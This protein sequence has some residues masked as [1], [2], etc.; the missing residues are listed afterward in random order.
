[1]SLPDE[2]YSTYDIVKTKLRLPDDSLI[3]ELQVYMTE[4]DTMINNKLQSKLGSYDSRGVALVYPL[5]LT[6]VPALDE[7]LQ[8]IANDLVEGKFRLK[9][10]QKDILWNEAL[11]RLDVYL[12]R[13]FG[14]TENKGFRVI[15][16]ISFTPNFGAS[17]TLVTISGNLFI[18]NSTITITF[19]GLVVATT[20]SVVVTDANGNFSGVTFN[21]PVFAS[22]GQPINVTDKT[23]GVTQNFRV[24]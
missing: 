12:D 16:T 2:H 13:K 19:G 17:G 15:Q 11:E 23:F 3:N 6:T 8:A 4:I 20:P 14:W 1:M 24:P 10:M 22:G 21:T 9:T 18:P 5:T 7:E